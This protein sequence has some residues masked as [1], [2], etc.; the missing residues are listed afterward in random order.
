MTPADILAFPGLSPQ[1]RQ[2]VQMRIRDGLR[3]HIIARR[4][5]MTQT[6]V[7]ALICTAR[8]RADGRRPPAR[9]KRTN[10]RALVMDADWFPRQVAYARKIAADPDHQTRYLRGIAICWG[11]AWSDRVEAAANAR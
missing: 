5:G 2:I 1:E 10:T 3:T 8:A 11:Q 7:S 4:L 9:D 6:Q